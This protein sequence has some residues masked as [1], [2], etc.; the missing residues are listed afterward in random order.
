MHVIHHK[1]FG[2]DVFGFGFDGGIL[3]EQGHYLPGEAERQQKGNF[4]FKGCDFAHS[5]I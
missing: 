3:E 2:G 5:G 1:G 4:I